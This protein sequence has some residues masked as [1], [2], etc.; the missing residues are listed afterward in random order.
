MSSWAF[1]HHHQVWLTLFQ[2]RQLR[3]LWGIYLNE[4]FRS[5]GM[6]LIGIF[7]PVYVYGLT[8]QIRPVFIFYL[9][10][11][12]LALVAAPFVGKLMQ[13]AGVDMVAVLGA[14]LR[15]IFMGLLIAAQSRL[16][17]LWLS[18]FA[19]GLAVATTWLPYHYTVVAEDDGDGKFG[20]EVARITIA[21]KVASAVAPFIGGLII[22]LLGFNSLYIAGIAFVAASV[23]PILVDSFNKKGMD[24]E[25]SHMF[26]EVLAKKNLPITVSLTGEAIESQVYGVMRPLFVFL[27]LASITQLGSIESVALV[28]TMLIILWA[29][30]WVDKKGMGLM[31]IGVVI[32]AL[33]LMLLPFFTVAW[34]FFLHNTIYLLVAVLVWTPFGAGVYRLATSGR[35]LEFFVGREI[36]IHL[37]S[38]ALYAVFLLLFATTVS[39]YLVFGFGSFGLLM[40][41]TMLRK[42]KDGQI[43]IGL[44]VHPATA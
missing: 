21:Q 40:T 1:I 30:A 41:L 24:Y 42:V 31:K 39:W 7:I 9:I 16:S 14:V 8:G 38:A 25:I 28:A 26:K 37:A 15:V 23:F 2:K 17:L 12:L 10:Y 5:L 36:I 6:S 29:G 27:A 3:G 34:E 33:A 18:A 32:N 11:H 22:F 20:H 4:V 19:W 44:K 35:K 13:R 43:D